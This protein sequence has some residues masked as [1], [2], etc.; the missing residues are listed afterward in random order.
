MVLD[1]NDFNLGPGL[2]KVIVSMGITALL[3]GITGMAIFLKTHPGPDP[4][5]VI[6]QAAATEANKAVVQ[7]QHASDAVQEV[8]SKVENP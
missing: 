3:T 7:A 4:L 2:K 8:K 1:P 6:L 5:Q